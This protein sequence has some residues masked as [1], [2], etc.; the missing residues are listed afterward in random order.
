MRDNAIPRGTQSVAP[1]QA[2]A[3]PNDVCGVRFDKNRCS[4]TVGAYP[5]RLRD[6][7]KRSDKEGR[8]QQQHALEDKAARMS[9]NA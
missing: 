9:R 7:A 1:V 8:K 2:D 4:S 3:H 6:D 5:G